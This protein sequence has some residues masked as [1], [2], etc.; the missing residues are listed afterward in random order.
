MTV[1]R[2]AP[3]DRD[4]GDLGLAARIGAGLALE[5]AAEISR[6]EEKVAPGNNQAD[7]DQERPEAPGGN[8]G[9]A[10]PDHG[11]R[12]NTQASGCIAHH[13]DSWASTTVPCGSRRTVGFQAG[14]TS[15]SPTKATPPASGA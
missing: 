3:I 12:T 2:Q 4:L 13:A 6:G 11:S 7:Q 15:P 14:S 9:D 10:L 5:T 1:W 8:L